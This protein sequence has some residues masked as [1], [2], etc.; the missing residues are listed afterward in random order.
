MTDV[1]L[2]RPASKPPLGG[3]PGTSPFSP[4]HIAGLD[5][6]AD[7]LIP[8]GDGF[9]APSRVDVVSFVQRY[10]TPAGQDARWYPF[11]TEEDVKRHLDA[12]GPLLVEGDEAA[13]V[14]LVETLERD[15]PE[16]F[17]RIR[18]LVY[19]A[20]YSRPEVI[21]AINQQ[22]PAGRD[23]RIT[24]QPFGYSSSTIDWDDELLSRVKGTYIP[25]DE[26]RRVPLPD[27]LAGPGQ[28]ARPE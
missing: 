21:R 3:W 7:T 23:Y 28:K 17:A 25:T 26:V 10:V 13:R 15:E 20:Y 6:L 1:F 4:A 22:L 18:D 11:L 12:L 2:G 9:P 16:F 8:G 27:T 14:R 24:P 5:A 19:Q